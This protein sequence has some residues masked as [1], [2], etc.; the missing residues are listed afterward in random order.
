MVA[1][2]TATLS[3][4]ARLGRSRWDPA[5]ALAYVSGDRHLLSELLAMFIADG[6]AH[7]QAL[8]AAIERGDVGEVTRLAHMLKGQ[9][10]TFGALSAASVAE[11]LEVLGRRGCL[12]GALTLFALLEQELSALLACVAGE[13]WR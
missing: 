1:E 5:V 7:A 11:W 13:E 2:R 4:P 6:P 12:S 9:L 10:R 3:T 8:R